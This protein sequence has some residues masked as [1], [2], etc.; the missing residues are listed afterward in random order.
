MRE[1]KKKEKDNSH[2]EKG[3]GNSETLGFKVVEGLR[4]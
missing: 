3:I 1:K 2:R 4:F